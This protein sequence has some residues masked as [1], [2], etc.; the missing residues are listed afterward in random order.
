VNRPGPGRLLALLCAGVLNVGIALLP[1]LPARPAR[2]RV[3]PV[4]PPLV[5]VPAAGEQV[6][7][8]MPPAPPDALLRG[9]ERVIEATGDPAQRSARVTLRRR[10]EALVRARG[11]GHA[12]RAEVARATA[13]LVARLGPERTE[14]MIA[15]RERLSA[16]LAE[17]RA[18][19]EAVARIA[20]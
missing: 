10:A 2:V 6:L 9:L 16:S 4:A 1:P 11:G 18:W 7:G 20:P 17:G 5:H 15:A 19:D 3:H 14:A 13:G 8:D 12:P